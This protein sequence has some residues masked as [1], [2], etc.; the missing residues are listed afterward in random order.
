M[1]YATANDISL[2]LSGGSTNI[3]P[4]LSLGGDPSATPVSDGVI[5]NLFDDILPEE[6]TE[7][8]EDYRCVYYFNDGTASVYD[9][10][11]YIDEDFAGGATVEL[12]I[13]SRDE[14]QRITIT[15][16]P[17]GGDL[18]LD[19]DGSQF[20]T[21]HNP[22]LSVWA[23][24]LQNDLRSLPNLQ[25][26]IV[27]AQSAGGGTILFDISFINDDGKKNHPLIEVV[28]NNLTPTGVEVSVATT[29]QGAPVNT[30]ASEI[31]VE[32]TPPGNIGF[33]APSE[34]SPITIP[35]LRPSEGFPLWVK[36]V[37]EA[38]VDPKERDGFRLRFSA[39]TLE[40]A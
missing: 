26:V 28:T 31:D 16:G 22:D 6:A 15:N 19:Y 25:D 34:T 38:G 1:A 9:I 20:I 39:Q 4:N 23:G 27:I 18:R 14:I 11:L 35:Q 12:G 29:T 2:V 33:Y 13:E 5:N 8:H 3:N 40:P 21:E 10:E 37:C 32:T 7:G 17:S 36:R 30:I 24:N